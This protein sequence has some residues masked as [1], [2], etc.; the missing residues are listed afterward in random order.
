MKKYILF[1]SAL[2]ITAMVQSC[3]SDPDQ[4]QL[5]IVHPTTGL[6]YA[7][8][9]VDSLKFYT[10]D[11]WKVTPNHSWLSVT[12]D[13]EGTINYDYNA[14]YLVTVPV[15]A[16]PNKTGKSRIGTIEVNSYDYTAYGLY[17]Q[18]GYLHFTNLNATV[19]SYL[20]Q[21]SSI[22]ESVQ[23]YLADSAFVVQDSLC[24]TVEK[25]WELSFPDGEPDWMSLSKTTGR[26]G[27]N[28]VD[29]AFEENP[30]YVDR[31]TTVRLTSS[32]VTT[33]VAVTQFAKKK[34]E[35]EE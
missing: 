7:D 17:I 20:S 4:H 30:T 23:F 16:E 21:Y 10:F 11:S 15:A 19:S 24:F 29:V 3:L 32:G 2:A 22:P 13:S 12:G 9:T 25:S 6:M 35:G 31:K 8:A 1:L 5:A 27:N 34:K 28:H 26:G 18:L 14:R 33:D